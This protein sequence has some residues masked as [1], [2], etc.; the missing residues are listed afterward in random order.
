MGVA[1]GI[2]VVGEQTTELVRGVVVVRR[3]LCARLPGWDAVTLWIFGE[4]EVSTEHSGCEVDGGGME[5]RAEGVADELSAVGPAGGREVRV[6]EGDVV[7]P[8][9]NVQELEAAATRGPMVAGDDPGGK[10]HDGYPV[11]NAVADRCIA[12]VMA[13]VGDGTG[14]A[15][16][17]SRLTDEEVE[18]RLSARL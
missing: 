12:G 7:A 9:L 5:G 11:N 14:H 18:A 17:S 6:G 8:D 4:V 15:D 13:P 1:E 16:V 3:S 10:A 2:R